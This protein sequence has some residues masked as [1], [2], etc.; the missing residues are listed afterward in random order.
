MPGSYV[1][2]PPDGPGPKMRTFEQDVQGDMVH[3][4]YHQVAEGDT[5]VY[6]SP[7]ITPAANKLF[8][9]F[10]NN[11]AGQKI[12]LRGLWLL[13]DNTAVTGVW[14][15]FDL[16]RISAVVGGSAITPQIMDTS[17]TAISGVTCVSSPTS[18]TEGVVLFPWYGGGEETIAAGTGG[19]PISNPV[20]MA[21]TNFIPV[22]PAMKTPRFNNGEGFALKMVTGAAGSG[23]WVINMIVS[24]E[25]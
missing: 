24:K 22:V 10:V 8:V 2:L 7:S 20:F 3:E 21:F 18:A 1:Q 5:W 6:T 17:D 14:T 13:R 12:A 15:T 23:N 16:K 19:N 25:L 11:T 9:A 4:V